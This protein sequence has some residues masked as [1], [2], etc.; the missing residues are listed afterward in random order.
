MCVIF[1]KF[2]K[3][4]RT[5]VKTRG[6]GFIFFVSFVKWRILF[7]CCLTSEKNYLLSTP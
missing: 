5:A 4:L 2:E 3:K 1:I 7:V 6:D